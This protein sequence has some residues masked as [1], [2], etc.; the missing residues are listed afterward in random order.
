MEPAGGKRARH[1]FVDN[2]DGDGPNSPLIA[3]LKTAPIDV[4]ETILMNTDELT[5]LEILIL[6]R[7]IL[8][9][10]HKRSPT[11]A[12][13]IQ[14]RLW[15]RILSRRF[16][17][18]QDYYATRLAADMPNPMFAFMAYAS[19]SWL[20]MDDRELRFKKFL[21]IERSL[22]IS[23]GDDDDDAKLEVGAR[24]SATTKKLRLYSS[25]DSEASYY[26]D[27]ESVQDELISLEQLTRSTQGVEPWLELSSAHWEGKFASRD[28]TRYAAMKVI[29]GLLNMGYQLDMDTLNPKKLWRTKACIGCNAAEAAFTCTGCNR[30][31][32]CSRGCQMVH[33]QGGHRSECL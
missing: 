3:F 22:D 12:A 5:Q 23:S 6:S 18:P 20:D 4:L 33:W 24:V 17:L 27:S 7:R 19:G 16:N 13:G 14:A 9:L 25:L 21:V 29:Y 8:N 1:A 15:P 10:L 26:D 28:D 32:Y 30:A 2:V 31:N 11:G